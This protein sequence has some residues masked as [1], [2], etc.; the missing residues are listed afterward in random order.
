MVQPPGMLNRLACRLRSKSGAPETS[1]VFDQ[2]QKFGLY[3][4]MARTCVSST[5]MKRKFLLLAAIL[6][7]MAVA[8]GV[9]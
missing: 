8:F 6:A 5:T 3:V 1:G 9:R 2:S 7:S 4:G